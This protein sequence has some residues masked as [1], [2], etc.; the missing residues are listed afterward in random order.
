MLCATS[1]NLWTSPAVAGCWLLQVLSEDLK[2]VLGQQ[3]R[4]ER[5]ADTWANPV[6][7]D[8]LGEFS[9][10]LVVLLALSGRTTTLF[11]VTTSWCTQR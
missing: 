5:G 10:C 9:C 8:K 11:Q 1:Y 6:S 2:L 3:E 4:M 7:Y